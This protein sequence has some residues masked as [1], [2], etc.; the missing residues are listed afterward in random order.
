MEFDSVIKKRHSVRSFKPKGVSWKRIMDAI[1]TATQIPTAGNNFNLKFIIVEHPEKIEKLAKTADQLWISEAQAV[2]I[3]IS[4]DKQLENLYGERGRVYS[5]QQAGASIEH[6]LLKLTD[7]GLSACWI[8]AYSD[9]Q[10]R[11]HFSIP[12]N[13][14]IEAIIPIGY[15]KPTQKSKASKP[16][17]P[18]LETSI[19]WEEWGATNRPALFKEPSAH[20]LSLDTEQESNK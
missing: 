9:E 13:K 4:D 16:K 19:Y 17:K 2:I 14:Q 7:L 11:S 20:Y 3:V 10:V 12:P 1:E 6:I 15:E 18:S 8:G 5:R